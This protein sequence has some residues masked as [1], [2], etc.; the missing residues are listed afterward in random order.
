MTAVGTPLVRVRRR[1]PRPGPAA[2]VWLGFALRRT[3]QLVAGV[4]VLAT[5]VFLALRAVPGD[6]A[7]RIAGADA[8]EEYVQRLRLGLGLDRPL[9]EQYATFMG[10]LATGDFGDSFTSGRPVVDVIGERL[11][12]TASLAVAAFAVIMVSSLVLGLLAIAITRRRPGRT[13]ER[14]FAGG[15]GTVASIPEFVASTYL[16]LFFAVF[17]SWLPAG[18]NQGLAAMVL[19]VAALSLRPVAV[20]TRIVRAEGLA[21]F[22]SDYIRVARS[23]RL[24]A[25]LIYLRHLLPNVLTS[26][27]TV[28]GLLLGAMLGGTV[29]VENLFAW[30]GL[31]S[32]VVAAVVAR[33]YTLVQGI[34][35]VLGA[36]V[37]LINTLVDV[38]LAIADPR[39]LVAAP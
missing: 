5:V 26:S 9:P 12:A 22:E 34:V 7:R 3:V 20:L 39:S 10:D 14:I 6:P 27:L 18:G 28:G 35:I 33:D 17:L 13:W 21:A 15:T 23:K 11:P 2:S 30:P 38:V 29:I 25:R 1:A 16:I 24:P 36:A 32:Q 19:P 4:V 8:T 37:L 31:G